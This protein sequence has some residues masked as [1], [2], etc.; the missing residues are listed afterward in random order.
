MRNDSPEYHQMST[1]LLLLDRPEKIVNVSGRVIGANWDS[2][3]VSPLAAL[4]GEVPFGAN[5]ELSFA[6]NVFNHK[7]NIS[8]ASDVQHLAELA[9]FN[10]E[11]C[12]GDLTAR[13]DY[14]LH[15]GLEDGGLYGVSVGIIPISEAADIGL[16]MESGLMW[17]AS[18]PADQL[19]TLAR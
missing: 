9:G 8:R 11:S 18:V 16:L 7:L 2:G 19:A 1:G 14:V 4:A 13:D 10:E 5:L 12:W 17:S 3:K 15:F 6:Y